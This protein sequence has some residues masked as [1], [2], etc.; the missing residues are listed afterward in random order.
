MNTLT[1]FYN[2]VKSF[3]TGVLKDFNEIMDDLSKR[4]PRLVRE[5]GDIGPVNKLLSLKV[6]GLEKRALST[7]F[8]STVP[9][10]F[11]K[12]AKVFLKKSD[13]K[14]EKMWTANGIKPEIEQIIDAG[15]EQFQQAKEAAPY[16]FSIDA[17]VKAVHRH[18]LKGKEAGQVSEATLQVLRDRLLNEVVEETAKLM[19]E[20]AQSVDITTQEAVGLLGI[21]GIKAVA[22]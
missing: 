11:D 19:E 17:V 20:K 2:D 1:K 14:A 3:E 9:Y 6:K 5:H 13:K 18:I 12:K 21:N 16:Q 10:L 7:Y 15:F 8:A 22:V 4:A